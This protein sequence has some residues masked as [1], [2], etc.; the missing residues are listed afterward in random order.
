MNSYMIS[1]R[2]E[3]RPA[4]LIIIVQRDMG[5]SLHADGG[6]SWREGY[7]QIYVLRDRP[8]SLEHWKQATRG[9]PD[10]LILF[11]EV[12]GKALHR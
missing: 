9:R 4:S 5:F 7:A 1:P 8:T 11:Q 10:E 3:Q 2:Y 12:V 6:V